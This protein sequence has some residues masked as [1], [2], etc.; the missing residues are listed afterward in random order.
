MLEVHV[1]D[2]HCKRLK[3]VHVTVEVCL[4]RSRHMVSMFFW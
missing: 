3:K 4:N 1:D 2:M